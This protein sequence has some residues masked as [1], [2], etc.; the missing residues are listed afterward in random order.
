MP[1]W[2][3]P[4]H[5]PIRPTLMIAFLATVVLAACSYDSAD[6]HAIYEKRCAGCHEPHARELVSTRLK[7]V[8]SKAWLEDG[9][10]TLGD[11]LKSH[12]TPPLANSEQTILVDHMTAMLA[13]GFIFGEKCAGCHGRAVQFARDNLT[14]R[15]GALVSAKSGRDVTKFLATHGYARPAEIPTIVSILR[16]QL[17]R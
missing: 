6:P 8:D 16:R 14:E 13:T 10:K 7:R 5:K 17:P 2:N 3:Y 15:D 11:A 9:S 4:P 1:A 12:P